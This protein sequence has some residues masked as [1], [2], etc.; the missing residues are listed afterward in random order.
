MYDVREGV[1]IVFGGS[2]FLE[3]L[4]ASP[5]SS[6]QSLHKY[7]YHCSCVGLSFDSNPLHMAVVIT[8]YQKHPSTTR[9]SQYYD[10]RLCTEEPVSSH[11]PPA[12]SLY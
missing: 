2:V 5:C 3:A 6:R 12:I 4:H 11:A 7:W 8:Y 9:L 10:S 1:C